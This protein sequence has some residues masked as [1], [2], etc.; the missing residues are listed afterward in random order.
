MN[1]KIDE[2]KHGLHGQKIV[3]LGKIQI[4]VWTKRIFKKYSKFCFFC[5]K[6]EVIRNKSV[7]VDQRVKI[8]NTNQWQ[9]EF[10]SIA[11]QKFQIF[12]E[13]LSM[14]EKYALHLLVV[15]WP[16]KLLKKQREKPANVLFFGNQFL[17]S[18]IWQFCSVSFGDR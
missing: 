13:K 10:L 12:F 17:N 14:V 7:L 4:L 16:E 8:N 2:T 6:I 15:C 18:I 9:C 1:P 3:L 11:I 5:Q